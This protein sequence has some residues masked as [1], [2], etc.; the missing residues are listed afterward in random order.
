M[1]ARL[2]HILVSPMFDYLF[3]VIPSMFKASYRVEN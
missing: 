1:R 2:I 3:I